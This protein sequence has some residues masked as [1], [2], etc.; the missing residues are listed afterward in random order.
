MKVLRELCAAFVLTLTLALSAFAGDIQ[1]MIT[2][3]PPP[4]QQSTTRAGDI[5]TPVAATTE[6][7]LNLLSGVLSLA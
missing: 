6:I 5:E 3:T 1:T 7:A 4:S 2:T